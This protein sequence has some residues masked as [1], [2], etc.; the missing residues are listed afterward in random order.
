M[1]QRV[2]LFLLF[3][4]SKQKYFLHLNLPDH[5]IIWLWTPAAQT[6]CT[7]FMTQVFPVILAAAQQFAEVHMR[8]TV[9]CEAYWMGMLFIQIC[10][11]SENQAL[12]N[13]KHEGIID[14]DFTVTSR[15]NQSSL[16]S[17]SFLNAK[18]QKI[19]WFNSY[20]VDC[21]FQ[22]SNSLEQ[23]EAQPCL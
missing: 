18:W 11:C 9:L 2:S 5:P 4:I 20:S 22:S 23:N 21:Y 3:W 13:L 12:G 17:F 14:L 16:L 19:C 8:R 7:R 6:G 10:A 15:L 1:G